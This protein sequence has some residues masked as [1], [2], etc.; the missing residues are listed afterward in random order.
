MENIKYSINYEM[1]PARIELP[2]N[3]ANFLSAQEPINFKTALPP[4]ICPLL[5]LGLINNTS[6]IWL[7]TIQMHTISN[8]K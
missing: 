2:W 1:N 6:N 4:L 7:Y 5:V 8:C 3:V